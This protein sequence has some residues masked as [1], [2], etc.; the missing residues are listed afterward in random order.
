MMR[1]NFA[2]FCVAIAALAAAP[3]LAVPTNKVFLLLNGTT[4]QRVN[5]TTLEPKFLSVGVGNVVLSDDGG[6]NLVVSG[7]IAQGLGAGQILLGNNSGQA[8]QVTPSGDWTISN[9]GIATISAGA[10]TNGKVSASAA[11]DYSKLALTGAIVDADVSASAALSYAKFAPFTA[12][13]AVVTDGS[14]IP[15]A[16]TTTATEIGYVNGVTS[17]I[18]TQLNGKQPNGSYITALTG[19][20][21]ATGPGSATATLGTVVFSNDNAG[22]AAALAAVYIKP[23]GNVDLASAASPS[24]ETS[25]IGITAASIGAGASGP[26]YLR[27]GTIIPGLSGLAPGAMVY[28]SKATPGA[29]TQSTTGF[30]PNTMVVPVGWAKSATELIYAPQRPRY[31]TSVAG[32]DFTADGILTTFTLGQTITGTQALRV[33]IDGRLQRETTDWSRGASSVV[34]TGAPNN[35]S[36][37]EVTVFNQ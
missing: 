29:L 22:T 16:A 20:V 27:R 26:V 30:D 13:R 6:G 19:E 2:K 11:I 33:Y 7:S 1:K 37:I 8:A 28:L 5:S 4:Q 10:I 12:G 34:F 18:Q 23:N 35:G 21:V 31:L 36:S 14:G 15:S 25:A 17:S 9:G 32:Y 3:A 24:I